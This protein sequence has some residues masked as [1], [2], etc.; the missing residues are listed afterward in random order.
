MEKSVPT[1]FRRFC[2]MGTS[3]DSWKVLEWTGKKES[4]SWETMQKEEAKFYRNYE[5]LDDQPNDLS[6]DSPCSAETCTP[7]MHV[8]PIGDA[9]Y[10]RCGLCLNRVADRNGPKPL[11]IFHKCG[12]CFKILCNRCFQSMEFKMW[13]EMML[14]TNKN[15]FTLNF[16]NLITTITFLSTNFATITF[17]FSFQ[18]QNLIF[19]QL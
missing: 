10:H 6:P 19:V 13:K 4:L 2:Q 17:L 18:I 16:T 15:E 8:G 12:D 3:I 11:E 5:G 14:F 1:S 9:P 7:V